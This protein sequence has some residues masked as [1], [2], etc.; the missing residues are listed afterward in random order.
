MTRYRVT[1]LI[2][3]LFILAF[4]LKAFSQQQ[5][6]AVES[7]SE[8][9]ILRGRLCL[10]F[11]DEPG[12]EWLYLHSSS[13]KAFRIKG[14]LKEE[15]KKAISDLGEENFVSIAGK[16]HNSSVSK[17]ATTYDYDSSGRRTRMETICVTY[18]D[19]EVTE[20]LNL[21]AEES[22]HGLSPLERNVFMEKRITDR[23]SAQ[24]PQLPWSVTGEME[25]KILSANIRTPIKTIKVAGKDKEMHFII[26]PS[27]RIVKI[28]DGEIVNL[29]VNSLKIRQKVFVIYRRYEDKT[30]ADIITIRE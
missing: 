17:C 7:E 24:P 9:K 11:L 26:K 28:M 19:L 14:E 2:L 29:S 20:I 30:E 25:G 8:L 23:I 3:F 27:T 13:G 4:S 5:Q 12:K 21:N 6:P 22:G 16:E 18:Y 1:I 10:C 15:L